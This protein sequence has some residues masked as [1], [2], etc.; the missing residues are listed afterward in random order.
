LTASF[1]DFIKFFRKKA[2]GFHRQAKHFE[3]NFVIKK[4]NFPPGGQTRQAKLSSQLVNLPGVQL[5]MK[6][7]KL[8]VSVS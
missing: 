1:K 3:L 6:R 4:K 8:P 5:L 2:T 7:L